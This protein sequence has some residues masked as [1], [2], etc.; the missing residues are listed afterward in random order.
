MYISNEYIKFSDIQDIKI[1]LTFLKAKANNEDASKLEKGCINRDLLDEDKKILT[2]KALDL[3]TFLTVDIYKKSINFLTDFD[4]YKSINIS[5]VIENVE[6]AL[7]ENEDKKPQET[8]P[9]TKPINNNTPTTTEKEK[10]TPT[11]T[12]KEK[13]TPTTT[14]KEKTTP[15]TTE[16]EKTTPTTTE[17]LI[18]LIDDIQKLA[19]DIRKENNINKSFSLKA[20]KHLMTLFIKNGS[21]DYRELQRNKK[22]LVGSIG[23]YRADL[24]NLNHIG[25]IYEDLEG[26]Y[27]LNKDKFYNDLDRAGLLK[28]AEQETRFNSMPLKERECLIDEYEAFR[29]GKYIKDG[30]LTFDFNTDS[31]EEYFTSSLLLNNTKY[32]IDKFR[33][34]YF[35]EKIKE[36]DNEDL[37]DNI[38]PYPILKF[39]FQNLPYTA[40]ETIQYPNINKLGKLLVVE[41]ELLEATPIKNIVICAEYEFGCS[42]EL[43]YFFREDKNIPKYLTKGRGED[44]E[45]WVLTKKYV[46]TYQELLIQQPIDTLNPTETPKPLKVVWIGADGVFEENNKIRVIGIL[47]I[48]K[49]DKPI[50]PYIINALQIEVIDTFSKQELLEED[51]RK[52]KEYF[53]SKNGNIQEIANDLLYNIKGGD[54][55]QLKLAV[56]LQQVNLQDTPK[57]FKN[58]NLHILIVSDPG[59]GKTQ[60]L[61]RIEEL[62]PNNIY[63]DMQNTT[64]SGLIGAMV[65][66]EGMIS[67]GSWY[68]EKGAIPLANGGVLCADEKPKEYGIKYI[69]EAMENGRISITKAT[70]PNLKLPANIASLYA[71]NPIR[72]K[73]DPNISIKE[74]IPM[75]ESTLSRF[76][77]ILAM[78]DEVKSFEDELEKLLATFDDEEEDIKNIPDDEALK[79]YILYAQTFNPT[80]PKDIKLKV[81]KYVHKLRCKNNV[82]IRIMWSIRKLCVALAKANLRDEVIE[83]DLNTAIELYESFLNTFLYDPETGKLDF[84]R[85]F[86]TT[87]KEREKMDIVLDAIKK[88]S[89]SGTL[90]SWQSIYDEVNEYMTEDELEDMLEKLKRNGEIVEPKPNKYAT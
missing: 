30:V 9:T 41:G 4:I 61:R 80:V 6:Q 25:W 16:K 32:Y 67:T 76:D 69:N 26:L 22:E 39:N 28:L 5:E 11:T 3:L 48:D 70:K 10:T 89:E 33:K 81:A 78:K 47:D 34:Q 90:A 86:G 29:E 72:E 59:M 65:K 77:L 74:Q 19:N 73:F 27:K 50:S 63:V 45:T 57:K 2:Q 58:Q 84:G 17:T 88:Y 43:K 56:L 83:E 15:T 18:N 53:K 51:I 62:F 24:A 64:Q 44:K 75:P 66:K 82:N 8:T 21:V 40:R 52:A 35:K 12:E 87:E 7:L 38:L 31:I 54:Y 1:L 37:F 71:M 36:L 55:D 85:V 23:T 68:Y 20:F 13:T 14:E 42:K 79:R 60:I 46:A 49:S